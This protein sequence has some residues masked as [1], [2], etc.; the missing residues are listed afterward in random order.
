MKEIKNKKRRQINIPLSDYNFI[1]DYCNR[2][3]LNMP[4]W[5]VIK[6]KEIIKGVENE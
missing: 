2:N 5:I 3:G 6:I 4:K 1:K